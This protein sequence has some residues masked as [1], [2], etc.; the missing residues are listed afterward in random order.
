MQQRQAD[1]S[2]IEHRDGRIGQR[3]QRRFTLY[4]AFFQAKP[5]HDVED[6]Q[7]H[8]I[9]SIERRNA[10]KSAKSGQQCKKHCGE[11]RV[12]LQTLAR[13]LDRLGSQR[14]KFRL[15]QPRIQQFIHQIVQS[16]NPPS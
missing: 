15:V 11:Q 14:V 10:G 16:G 4:A 7:D 6:R 9:P 8:I 1:G 3:H 5:D 13:L 12:A 2:G